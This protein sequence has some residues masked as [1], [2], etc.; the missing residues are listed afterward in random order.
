MFYHNRPADKP[1]YKKLYT[2]R[3]I[4]TEKALLHHLMQV[5]QNNKLVG[6]MAN[7][8]NY[9]R[10]YILLLVEMVRLEGLGLFQLKD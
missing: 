8:Q 10:Q 9:M 1:E 6:R 7:T 2:G 3:D 4:M 5:L